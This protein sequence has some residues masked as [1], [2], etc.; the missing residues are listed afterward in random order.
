MMKSAKV[1]EASKLSEGM[2]E[3]ESEEWEFGLE[4]LSK[5]VMEEES[6]QPK[7]RLSRKCM[8]EGYAA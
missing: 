1:E 3:G 8:I 6:I 7:E 4:S 5:R 2:T